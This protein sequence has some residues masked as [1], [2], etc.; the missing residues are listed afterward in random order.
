MN[1]KGFTLIELTTV[2]VIMAII[3]AILL[4]VCFSAGRAAKQR[5]CGDSLRQLHLATSLYATA[6]DGWYPPY[7]T[8]TMYARD[9]LWIKGDPQKWKQTLLDQ[10][11]DD[12]QFWCPLD[13]YKGDPTLLGSFESVGVE[14]QRY[15]S[16]QISELFGPQLFGSKEGALRLNPDSLPPM[17]EF[18]Q[19]SIPYLHDAIWDGPADPETGETPFISHHNKTANTMYLDGHIKNK[20][21]Q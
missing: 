17:G 19:S 8:T 4:P 9:G 7:A 11:A 16:Y 5:T 15:T 2:V 10:G 6:N 1:K 12:R 21:I 14:R 13:K 3:A 18:T 20:P